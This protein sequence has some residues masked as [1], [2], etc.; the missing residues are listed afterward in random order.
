VSGWIFA[1]LLAGCAA[2]TLVASLWLHYVVGAAMLILIALGAWY[3]AIFARQVRRA[4]R[5]RARHLARLRYVEV[6]TRNILA[7]AGDGIITVDESGVIRSFNRAAARIFGYPPREILGQRIGL[8]LSPHGTGMVGTG[9]AKILGADGELQ[10]MR[11]DGTRFPIEPALS[12]IRVGRRRRYTY[13]LRDLTERRRHEEALR[14]A[15]DELELRVRQRTTELAKANNELRAEVAR[16]RKAQAALEHLSRQN[17]L[18]L[19]AAGEGILG[20]HRAGNITFVN[21]AAAHLSG[22]A[23]EDLIGKPWHETIYPPAPN[24]AP[25]DAGAEA[26]VVRVED[27]LFHRKDG[28]WFSAQFIRAPLREGGTV[29]GAVVTFQDIT[30]R[31]KTQEAMQ[32]YAERLR[33]LSRQLLDLQEAERRHLARE[34]HDEVG[35]TLTALK[36]NLDALGKAWP[37]GPPPPALEDSLAVVGQ[38]IAEVRNLSL[39]LR[40]SHLDD[41]GLVPALRWYVERQA[42]RAGFHARLDANLDGRLSPDTETACFRVVQEALT[43]VMRHANAGEVAVTLGRRDGS[44]ELTVRDDGAGFDVA[45]ARRRAARGASL[46]LLGMQERVQLLGGTIDVQSAPGQGTEIRI[47][48]PAALAGGAP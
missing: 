26:A 11:K 46:G 30:E 31:K 39:D 35:Q 43:N 28:F 6:R 29:V 9:E 20:L 34:L 21:P 17:Q 15:R 22:W 27:A 10:G 12:K 40:P 19:Q 41:L 3:G 33:A 2:V 25:A 44:I 1:A 5:D 14:Q 32:D 16:R 18:I 45:A 37:D 23:A 42:Q 47:R 7:T 38:A 24:A 48:F 36:L 4:A 8:L 13:V